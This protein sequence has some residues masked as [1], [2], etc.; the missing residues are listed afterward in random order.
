M[1]ARHGRS[2]AALTKAPKVGGEKYVHAFR[3]PL[4]PRP[5][6]QATT[7]IYITALCSWLK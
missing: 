5:I 1:A 6:A 2:S 3:I 7:A 4:Y